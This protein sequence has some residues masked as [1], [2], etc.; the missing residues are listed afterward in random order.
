MESNEQ[1]AWA[2]QYPTLAVEYI[3]RTAHADPEAAEPLIE[4]LIEDVSFGGEGFPDVAMILAD[5]AA[6]PGARGRHYFARFVELSL[7]TRAEDL[8]EWTLSDRAEWTLACWV[9]SYTGRAEAERILTRLA[10][11]VPKDRKSVP[12]ECLQRMDDLARRTAE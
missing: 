4:R 11:E 1:W 3:A 8:S 6:E 5:V 10:E 7:R 12:L 9:L 2:H